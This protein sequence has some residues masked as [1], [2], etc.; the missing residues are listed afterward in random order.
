YSRR[1]SIAAVV[2]VLEAQVGRE[3]LG[4]S[5][6]TVG[7]TFWCFLAWVC[8]RSLLFG[9]SISAFNRTGSSGHRA[10]G[11][12]CMPRPAEAGRSESVGRLRRGK[13]GTPSSFVNRRTAAARRDSAS[14]SY[15]PR[16]CHS[17]FPPSS[18]R[19]R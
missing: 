2:E 3:D 11:S 10:E 16:P 5:I 17:R 1:R 15:C 7:T 9:V 8:K 6:G 18:G 13:G 4:T 14:R 19:A 12:C